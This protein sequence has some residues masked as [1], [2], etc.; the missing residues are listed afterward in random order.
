MRPPRSPRRTSST[1]RWRGT[2]AARRAGDARLQARGLGHDLAGERVV[3]LR[4]LDALGPPGGARRE[5]HRGPVARGR[6][7]G[8][9][10]ER[11]VAE[12]V[13]IGVGFVDLDRVGMPVGRRQV[14]RR[15]AIAA[16]EAD[17]RACAFDVRRR[18]RACARTD[19]SARSRR[20]GARRRARRRRRPASWSGPGAPPSPGTTPCAVS[21]DAIA[22]DEFVERRV[23]PLARHRP[24]APRSS[25]T[26]WSRWRDDRVGPHVAEAARLRPRRSR[27]SVASSATRRSRRRPEARGGRRSPGC[28]VMRGWVRD[29]LAVDGERPGGA[30]LA[31]EDALRRRPRGAT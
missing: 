18:A 26:G 3:G 23:R 16:S 4:D 11:V 25:G 20:R 6:S 13:E 28:S 27:R 8:Q 24:T 17:G 14:R 9:I 29:G 22:R 12:Q 10:G 19:R 5:H 15:L 2:V 1:G 30:G 7:L 21:P 31:A